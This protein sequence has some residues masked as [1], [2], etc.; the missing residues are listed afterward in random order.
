M[1]KLSVCIIAKNEEARIGRCLESV[2]FADEIIVV[3]SGSTDATIEICKKHGARVIEQ[4]WPG[5]AKQ[6][7]RAIDAANYS[8]IL[9]LDADEWMPKDAENIVRKSINNTEGTDAYFLGR[10]T[11]FLGS[12]IRHSG[13]YPDKQIRLFKKEAT[14]FLDV[15][16]HEKVAETEHT[17]DLN[18]DIWHESYTSLDQ[19]Y[20][21]NRAYTA[22]QAKQ[23]RQQRYVF[24]KLFAKPAYRFVQTYFVQ[25]GILDGYRGLQLAVL[26]SGYEFS[27][28]R[29]ILSLQKSERQSKS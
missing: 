4:D 9:S 24:M 3:D 21:K 12:W 1:E 16:V 13:W 8:W 19:W 27:V 6:K 25:L 5:W 29:Q 15:P 7:N 11:T 17:T 20:I 28:C 2:Q 10:R 26:R 22:A 23:Q 18:L 14:R